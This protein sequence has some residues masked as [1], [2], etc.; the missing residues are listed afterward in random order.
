[1][2]NACWNRQGL[3]VPDIGVLQENIFRTEIMGYDWY[4]TFR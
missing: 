2:L 4:L 3:F 1:M